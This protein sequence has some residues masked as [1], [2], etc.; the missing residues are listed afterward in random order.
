M[1]SSLSAW[2]ALRAMRQHFGPKVE[3]ELYQWYTADQH[4][5]S[6]RSSGVFLLLSRP[7]TEALRVLQNTLRRLTKKP[8]ALPWEEFVQQSPTPPPVRQRPSVR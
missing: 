5:L 1:T 3:D 4:T 2:E 6:Y 8:E 7:E